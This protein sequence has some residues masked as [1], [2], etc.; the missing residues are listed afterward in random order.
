[1][2]IGL[3]IAGM[4]IFISVVLAGIGSAVGIG[5][6]GQVAAGVMSEDPKNFGK[7]LMLIAL[8]GTQGIYGFVIGFLVIM[9][10]GILT[11]TVPSLSIAQGLNVFAAAAPIGFA[12]LVSA[13]HQG[14]VCAAGIEMAAKQPSD[15]GKALVMG[16]FVEFYAVLGL[17]ISF[18]LVW[19]GINL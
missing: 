16:V 2:T 5:L 7:Y 11:G 6:A 13:I 3:F 15:V 8:P 4:G 17:L 18:F 14:K 12:G 19:F 1:M 9:K 10:L